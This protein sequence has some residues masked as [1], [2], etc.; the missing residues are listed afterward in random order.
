MRLELESLGLGAIFNDTHAW[1]EVKE[2]LEQL[3]ANQ[4]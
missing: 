2:K 3:V 1:Y 4:I